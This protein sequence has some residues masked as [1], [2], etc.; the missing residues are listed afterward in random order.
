MQQLGEFVGVLGPT[1]DR[2]PEQD[3]SRPRG[4]AADIDTGVRLVAFVMRDDNH[5]E[6]REVTIG[7]RSDDYYEVL[8]DSVLEA[9]HNLLSDANFRAALKK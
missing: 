3:D 2:L 4:V 8:S 7:A 1:L 9:A 5:L 6:P